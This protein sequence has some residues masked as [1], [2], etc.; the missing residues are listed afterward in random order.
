MDK[1][2]HGNT[3]GIRKNILDAI[4]SLYDFPV[5]RDYYV[6]EEMVSRLAEYTAVIGREISLFMSRNGYVQDITIGEADR[7]ELPKMS[8]RRGE[9]RLKTPPRLVTRE[10]VRLRALR[11]RGG[12]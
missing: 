1:T 6:Q 8:L 7:V 10:Q 9:K 2:V 11:K 12:H 5:D 4:E 3:E